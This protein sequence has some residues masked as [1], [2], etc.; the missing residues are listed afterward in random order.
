MP[1]IAPPKQ[2][3]SWRLWVRLSV[4][5][6][7]LASLAL[8][9]HEVNAFLAHDARFELSCQVNESAC[10]SLEIRGTVHADKVR[11]QH[12]FTED[13]GGSVFRIPLAERRRHLLAV[14]WVGTAT[15]ARVWP[16]RLVVTVSERTPVAFAKL[17]M[18]ESGHYRMALIDSEGVLLSIPGRVRF[19]LPVLS[20]VTEDQ[21][22]ADR[23]TSVKAAQNLL[24][25]LGPQAKEIS[26]V[27]AANPQDMRVV[28][29]IAG[30]AVELWLGDQRYLPRYEHFVSHYEEIRKHSEDAGVFDL[31]M[32]DRILAK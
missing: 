5:T 10:T 28:T 22:E 29:Q 17:P 7:A 23:R 2:K 4:W 8:G 12:V 21:T 31:R 11:L 14:D 15:V 19:H 27:N 25:D 13:F 20:G 1:K 30:T 24:T 18:G 16:N 6:I 32:D 9:A 3:M 26:E